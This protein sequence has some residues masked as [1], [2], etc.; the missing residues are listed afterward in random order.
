MKTE[1]QLQ[2]YITKIARG[3]GLICDKVE[4]RSRVGWPD[5][6]IVAPGG[7]VVFVEV[8]SPAG[9]GR[10]SPSQAHVIAELRAMGVRVCVIDSADGADELV[11]WLSGGGDA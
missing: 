10:L 9:T 3:A 2:R 1:K 8:K 6:L 4:S 5:L 11:A 7:R